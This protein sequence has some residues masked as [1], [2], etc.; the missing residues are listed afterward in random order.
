MTEMYLGENLTAETRV[1]YI[2]CVAAEHDSKLMFVGR[3]EYGDWPIVQQA[4]KARTKKGCLSA[5]VL[6]KHKSMVTCASFA[7]QLEQAN[8]TK[9]GFVLPP[10]F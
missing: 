6:A 7:T 8:L 3:V 9:I 1:N 2:K 4:V 10:S 5:R